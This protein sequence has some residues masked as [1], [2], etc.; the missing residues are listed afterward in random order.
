MSIILNEEGG[1]HFYVLKTTEKP[2]RPRNWLNR[3]QCK[4]GERMEISG[5]VLCH[6]MR[7]K[8]L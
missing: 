3:N 7:L 4:K 2:Y 6:G 1:P 8:E 5:F